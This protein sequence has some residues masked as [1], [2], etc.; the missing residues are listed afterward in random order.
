LLGLIGVRVDKG[1]RM[2]LVSE[3]FVWRLFEIIVT[4]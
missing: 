4:A 1:V 2:M 3:K